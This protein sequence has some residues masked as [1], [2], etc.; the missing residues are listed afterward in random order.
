MAVKYIPFIYLLIFASILIATVPKSEINRLSIYGILFGAVF[1]IVLVTTANL[2]GE[3]RYINYGEFGLFGLHFFAPISWA[4]FYIMYFYFLPK[5][6]VY[7]Y[8]YVVCGIFYSM[9]FCQV[10]TKLGVLKL[11]HGILDSI[12]P[13]LIWLPLATWG[14][15]RLTKKDE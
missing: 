11:R 10:I 8:I 1:D 2:I 14:Y 12:I 4:V 6:K 15:L 9:F 13:F 3:F 7:I 5:K